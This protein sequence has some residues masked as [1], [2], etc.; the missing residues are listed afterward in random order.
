M[1]DI[2]ALFGKP[3][4][5]NQKVIPAILASTPGCEEKKTNITTNIRRAGVA[6]SQQEFQLNAKA[7]TR[8]C[9]LVVTILRIPDLDCSSSLSFNPPHSLCFLYF[10]TLWSKKLEAPGFPFLSVV[11]FDEPRVRRLVVDIALWAFFR[12]C[13]EFMAFMELAPLFSLVK[14]SLT[15]VKC[16][17]EWVCRQRLFGPG[18]S[19]LVEK[20][21]FFF[22]FWAFV[23]SW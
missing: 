3:E 11:V 22:Y 1:N 14:M 15:S 8:G 9:I 12:T 17:R 16:E 10:P 18:F 23:F 2:F 7:N 5:A 21:F 19:L 13:R 20:L 6:A 4:W